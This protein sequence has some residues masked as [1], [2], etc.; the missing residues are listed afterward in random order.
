[1]SD[2][3]A[4]SGVCAICTSDLLW[5]EPCVQVGVPVMSGDNSGEVVLRSKFAHADPFT[6]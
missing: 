2:T 5:G 6:S 4:S 1:M 3:I